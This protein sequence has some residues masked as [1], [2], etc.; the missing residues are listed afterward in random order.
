MISEILKSSEKP[1]LYEAGTHFMWTDDHI[2]IQLLHIHLNPDIDLASRKSSTIQSTVNWILDE[3]ATGSNLKILD[4]GCGPGLYAEAFAKRGHQ[5][6]GID[7]SNTSI[8]YAKQNAREQQLGIEY[9]CCSYLD[10]DFGD[11]K[12]DLITLIYTDFGVLK[13][14]QRAVLL[15]NVFK[16]LKPDGVFLFDV[17]RNGNMEQKLSPRIWDAQLNGFWKSI[18]HL[19]LS[20]S[21]Y[22][23][24]SDVIL[25]Q[26]QVITD[27]KVPEVYRFWTHFFTEDSLEIELESIGFSSLGFADDIVVGDDPFSGN[28]VL[29]VIATK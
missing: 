27:E 11:N 9:R 7:I 6:H 5:V 23:D 8:E 3:V 25:Y 29:F 21:F 24:D 18:P 4:L 12:Y 2:S 14:T 20:E 15:Q 22:Y 10:L 1:A 26:H 19:T 16:A 17:L 13:P 28:N